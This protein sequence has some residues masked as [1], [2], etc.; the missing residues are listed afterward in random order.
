M[1][2]SERDNII[3][4][5]SNISKID[6]NMQT[7]RDEITKLAELTLE[8][9]RKVEKEQKKLIELLN[10][11]AQTTESIHKDMVN[12]FTQITKEFELVNKKTQYQDESL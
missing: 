7:L 11:H 12:A 9:F 6:Y 5:V 3:T 2:C 4:I 10:N 1:S 8:D